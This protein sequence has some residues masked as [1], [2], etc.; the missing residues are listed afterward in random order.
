ME[1]TI[2]RK[3]TAMIEKDG[4]DVLWFSSAEP[5]DIP[6]TIKKLPRPHYR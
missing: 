2:I 6:S 3:E 5:S 1:L 4:G